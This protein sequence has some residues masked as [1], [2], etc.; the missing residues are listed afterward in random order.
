MGVI[1]GVSG[2]GFWGLKWGSARVWGGLR[3]VEINGIGKWKGF[4]GRDRLGWKDGG[5]G[6]K[7]SSLWGVD[8]GGRRME[9][10]LGRKTER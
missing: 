7:K 2:V 3:I 1:W 10:R 9:G 8:G 6:R 4:E 5:D